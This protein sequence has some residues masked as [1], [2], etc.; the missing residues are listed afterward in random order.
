MRRLAL[1][2]VA[3]LLSLAGVSAVTAGRTA[4][5]AD[6]PRTR[7]ARFA[8]APKPAAASNRLD[9]AFAALSPVAMINVN[10]QERAELRLYDS[11]GALSDG[12][13]ERIEELLADGRDPLKLERAPIDHRVLKLLFKAAYHFGAPEL[14]IVSGY[15][16]PG[17]RREGLHGQ[18][19]AIDFKLRGVKAAELAS[20]LRRLPRAGVGVYTHPKTQYVHLDVREQSYHW[21]DA[22]PPR[23][24][25]RERSLGRI[26][27]LH[28]RYEPE[29]DLPDSVLASRAQP[30]SPDLPLAKIVS[31]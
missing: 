3:A 15:R 17:R 13:L 22:S 9:P 5:S 19:R 28:D 16:K 27:P 30:D 29:M 10:T 1:A 24:T 18:G 26:A 20:Y 12:A 7:T 21:L 2:L 11:S 4:P 31:M 23:R 14:E 8:R 25:W 6:I